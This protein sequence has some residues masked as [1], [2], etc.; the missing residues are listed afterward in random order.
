MEQVII[1]EARLEPEARKAIEAQT[2][3]LILI[4]K[5][6][7][8][9]GAGQRGF[10]SYYRNGSKWAMVRSSTV[11]QLG[12]WEV[13]DLQTGKSFSYHT[14]SDFGRHAVLGSVN[15]YYTAMYHKHVG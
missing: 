3:K 11:G 14:V 5:V 15:D 2:D 12:E 10:I 6:V 13:R 7:T 9:E 1:S 4:R 8:D